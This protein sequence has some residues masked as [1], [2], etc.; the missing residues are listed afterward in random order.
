MARIHKIVGYMID[1]NNDFDSFEELLD[2]TINNCKYGGTFIDAG[3]DTSL[4]F[5]WDDELVINQCDCTLDE[6]E[7]YFKQ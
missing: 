1:A 5:D 4:E 3:S 7:K 6:L 2:Y